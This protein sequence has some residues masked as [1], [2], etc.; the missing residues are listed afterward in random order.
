MQRE[1][2]RKQVQK[3][4]SIIAPVKALFEFVIR[5]GPFGIPRH[6]ITGPRD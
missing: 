1:R 3:M 6:A 2:A 5:L 4:N